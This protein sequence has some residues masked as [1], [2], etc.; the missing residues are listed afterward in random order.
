ME[1][2]T[3]E[4]KGGIDFYYLE[5]PLRFSF[6]LIPSS[7]VYYA[8]GLVLSKLYGYDSD[9][10]ESLLSSSWATHLTFLL[11]PTDGTILNHLLS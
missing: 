11:Y 10:T 1:H 9:P 5:P 6:L 7:Y 3:R 2:L 4:T 8:N